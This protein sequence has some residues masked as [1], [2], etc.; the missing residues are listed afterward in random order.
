MPAATK[1]AGIDQLCV[2]LKAG[3]EGAIH[4]TRTIWEKLSSEPDFVVLSIDAENAFN[5]DRTVMQWTEL[6][7]FGQADTNG[8]LVA[9][10]LLT[11]TGTTCCSLFVS[12]T[13]SLQQN[14]CHSG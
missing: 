6:S 4:A 7:C 9:S 10:L 13:P 14:W 12:P 1:A 11:A 3:V 8:P 2:G 5:M